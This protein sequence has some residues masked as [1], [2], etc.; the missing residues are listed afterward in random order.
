MS[1]WPSQIREDPSGLDE[2][3]SRA[4]SML[5][6]S[7]Y[8]ENYPTPAKLEHLRADSRWL[9]E[10]QNFYHAPLTT[11]FHSGRNKAGVFMHPNRGSGHEC[12]GLND[13]SKN[14]VATSYLADAWNW[15]AEIFCGCEVRFVEKMEE[16]GY[17]VFFAWH[18]SGRYGI[19]I[20]LRYT[21]ITLDFSQRPV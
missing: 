6:P 8:P 14:T 15:D 20:F 13:G 12:T 19:F 7:T 2:Y 3:Y 1:P 4:E 16:G 11:F 18:G 17:I 9:G 5:Q 21:S 10:E